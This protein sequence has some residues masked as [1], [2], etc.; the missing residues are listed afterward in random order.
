MNVNKYILKKQF[1]ILFMILILN[2]CSALPLSNNQ[3]ETPTIQSNIPS[4]MPLATIYYLTITP[5]FTP[6]YS[7]TPTPLWIN[8]GPG[9]IVCPILLYHRIQKTELLS[10]YYVS[11]EEF[12]AQMQSLKEWGY[13]TISIFQ[14]IQAIKEG[15]LLPPRPIIV[16][17]D[18]GDITVYNEAFP[19]MRELGF[20]G[21][22]FLVVNYIGQPGY[23]NKEQIQELVS[24]GWEVGSH[25]M[26]HTD[27][28]KTENATWEMRQSRI[29]LEALFGVPVTAFAFPFGSS[30]DHLLTRVL[31]V[32]DAGI[33]LGVS[34]TQSKNN[35]A[36]LWR[37]PIKPGWDL[38]TFGSYL[39]YHDF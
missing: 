23:M 2:N 21:I 28:T 11:P 27:L 3:L 7:Y 25:S 20:K 16:S 34:V 31:T 8:Q 17:F 39:P 14:L 13:E 30:N 5:V 36:Y 26:T 22:N 4:I 10:E 37:R 15:A 19:V 1:M 32:Y 24:A 9:K 18:D 33:G 6:T 35:L 12:K 29:V 38:E